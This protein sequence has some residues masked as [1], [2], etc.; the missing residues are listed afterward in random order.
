ML[1]KG[2]LARCD[3]CGKRK[4]YPLDAVDKHC[5]MHG[6]LKGWGFTSS[7]KLL[8]DECLSEYNQLLVRFMESEEQHS[9]IIYDGDEPV[10]RITTIDGEQYSI[11]NNLEQ[12]M[13]YASEQVLDRLHGTSRETS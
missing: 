8:C 2:I 4:F 11:V 10:K 7:T 3:R 13:V 1:E 5:D 9:D 6:V 12:T